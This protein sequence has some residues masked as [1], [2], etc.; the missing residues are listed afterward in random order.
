MTEYRLWI[1]IPS[2]PIA[3]EDRWEPLIAKLENGYDLGAVIG[4]HDDTA[5]IVVS[6]PSDSEAHATRVAIGAITEA[7]EAT[8]LSEL[9]PSSVEVEA[10]SQ[11]AL[12]PA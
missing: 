6:L 4:W 8:E 1:T 5:E 9:Y 11:D 3:D 2:L 10:V 12:T 7:L